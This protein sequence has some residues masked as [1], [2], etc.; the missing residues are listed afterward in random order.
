MGLQTAAAIETSERPLI[1]PKPLV[2]YCSLFSIRKRKNKVS[3]IFVEQQ[4]HFLV[5]VTNF[6]L[7]RGSC[8]VNLLF[9]GGYLNSCEVQ[10][11]AKKILNVE[12]K[13]TVDK[14]TAHSLL[15]H[16]VIIKGPKL[17]NYFMKV[18]CYESKI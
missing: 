6:I 5:S 18:L 14:E 16:T 13:F 17:Y 2:D 15:Y 10:I 12:V 7:S 3:T 9:R 1:T 8:N 4:R 11:L